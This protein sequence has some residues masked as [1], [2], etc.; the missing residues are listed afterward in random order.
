MLFAKKIR[1]TVINKGKLPLFDTAVMINNCLM[2]NFCIFLRFCNQHKI[3]KFVVETTLEGHIA[4]F[5]TLKPNWQE[6]A[7]N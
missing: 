4:F 5:E 3:L 6:T 7:Q 1:Q 2:S